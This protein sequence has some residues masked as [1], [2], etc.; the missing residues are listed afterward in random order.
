MRILQI[1][2]VEMWYVR[3]TEELLKAVLLLCLIV[4]D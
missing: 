1:K 2:A 4:I 3:T